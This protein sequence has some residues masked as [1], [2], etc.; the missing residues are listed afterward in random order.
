MDYPTG[1]ETV[2]VGDT[3]LTGWTS[4]DLTTLFQKARSSGIVN[5]SVD[6]S[7]PE[8]RGVRSV[9]ERVDIE[10]GDV[11]TE[12]MYSDNHISTLDRQ[13][14]LQGCIPARRAS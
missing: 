10:S 6:T 11:A 12:C 8:K 13:R 7:A 14:Q 9:Y 4:A 3:G 2:C 5:G 1:F